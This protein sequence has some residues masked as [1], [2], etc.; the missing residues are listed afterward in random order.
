M[1]LSNLKEMTR[2]KE[3]RQRLTEASSS[4]DDSSEFTDEFYTMAQDISK[5]KKQMKNARWMDWMKS[6][7]S[8]FGTSTVSVAQKAIDAIN[9]LDRAFADLDEQFDEA[10]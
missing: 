5:M 1:S 7:D 4:Y 10:N 9:A 6:T 2:I 3:A 8:N